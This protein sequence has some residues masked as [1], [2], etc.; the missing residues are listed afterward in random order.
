MIL[1]IF[2]MSC[3]KLKTTV[4]LIKKN[5]NL[6]NTFWTNDLDF[7]LNCEQTQVLDQL[8]SGSKKREIITWK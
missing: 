3:A 4:S 8:T 7:V 1:Y 5:K 2:E 6:K